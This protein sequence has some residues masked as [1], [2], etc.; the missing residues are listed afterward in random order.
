MSNGLE[1]VVA[2]ETILSDVDGLAGRLIIRGQPLDAAD[3]ERPIARR[4]GG[5]GEERDLVAE[6]RQA[7][8]DAAGHV[9]WLSAGIGAAEAEAD[10]G[11]T[12]IL[13]DEGGRA[14]AAALDGV[15]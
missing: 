5:V 13:R 2:A 9:P 3:P 10:D 1:D 12:S 15:R 6:C 4:I 8:G 11:E 14:H 7:Q